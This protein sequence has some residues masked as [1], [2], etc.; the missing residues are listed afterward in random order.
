MVSN[1]NAGIIP[2]K[3]ALLATVH[4][5]KRHSVD[6]PQV[7]RYRVLSLKSLGDLNKQTLGFDPKWLVMKLTVKT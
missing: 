3:R 1:Y 4:T 5:I 2:L 6:S 7:K